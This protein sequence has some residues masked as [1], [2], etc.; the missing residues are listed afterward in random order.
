M[1]ES[2]LDL[3]PSRPQSTAAE[4]RRVLIVL[5]CL[6]LLAIFS[7]LMIQ[8]LGTMPKG[9]AC[10]FVEE[11]TS[12]R[13]F[14]AGRSVYQPLAETVPLYFGPR[15]QAHVPVN[16]HPPVAVLAAL[17]AGLVDFRLAWQAWNVLSLAALA[18]S[19]WLLLRPAGLNYP[20][21]TAIPVATLLL[22]SNPLAQQ[23]LEGQ[24]NLFLL[25]LL[26]GAWAADRADRP[27]LAG[28][29]IG[30]ATAIKLYPGLIVVYF[31]ARGRWSAVL[32]AGGA[33]A[34]LAAAACG[35]FG[36]DVFLVYF[37]DVIPS[38]AHYR[39]NLANASLAGL[40]SKVFVGAEGFSE[41][42]LHAPAAAKWA[43][44]ASGLAIAGLCGWNAWRARTR[45]QLDLAFAAC[46][47]GALLASPI[48]W[49]HSFVLLVLPLLVAWRH[50]AGRPAVRGAWAGLCVL[51]WLVR[52]G[53][54]WNLAPGFEALSLAVAP[55]DL[56]IA[57]LAALTII[58]YL[59]YALLAAFA[60][61]I[62]ARPAMAGEAA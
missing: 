43:T 60:L 25:A 44:L 52:C 6:P 10:D 48:T 2:I 54:I 19:V 8:R 1:S 20:A 5:A 50:S 56:R 36:G 7:W 29:L 38:F 13:N 53:W 45:P 3:A 14:M 49:G 11:W 27:V 16:G 42:L 31:L 58:A 30:V 41:P 24:L 40:W 57:P 28:A 18:G 21:W 62:W 61:A 37:R 22:A 34:V 32:A 23:V 35:L 15:A 39:H 46:I 9:T 33:F 47:V 55:P 4:Q 51:L 59:T 12:A 17:P 26:T